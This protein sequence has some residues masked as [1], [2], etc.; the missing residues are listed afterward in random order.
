MLYKKS[1]WPEVHEVVLCTVTRIQYTSVFVTLDEYEMQ[2]MLHISEVSP[3][4]IRNLNDY[5]KVGK[6]MKK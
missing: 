2:G 6:K 5:V 3:G 4:R 1:G